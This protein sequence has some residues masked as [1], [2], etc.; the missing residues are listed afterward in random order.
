ML[1]PLLAAP[2]WEGAIGKGVLR[3]LLGFF[4]SFWVDVN[5]KGVEVT[6]NTMHYVYVPLG[7]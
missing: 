5:G 1:G 6:M 3:L 2:G 4:D 7:M